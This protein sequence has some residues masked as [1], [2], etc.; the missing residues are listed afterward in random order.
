MSMTTRN[1][2][3]YSLKGT[4]GFQVVG[5]DLK[6]NRNGVDPICLITFGKQKMATKH[7]NKEVKNTQRIRTKFDWDDEFKVE[8]TNPNAVLELKVKDSKIVVEKASIY[9]CSF[10]KVGTL[11]RD[12]YENCE[13]DFVLMT[14]EYTSIG[15]VTLRWSWVA[16]EDEQMFAPVTILETPTTEP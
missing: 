12:D 1:G 4:L 16:K 8:V 13:G 14:S 3:K 2:E 10:I 9:G 7:Y 6:V 5:C 11:I 15:I